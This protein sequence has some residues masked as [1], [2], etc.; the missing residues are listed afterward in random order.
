MESKRVFFAAQVFLGAPIDLHQKHCL[1]Q[2]ILSDAYFKPMTQ[3]YLPTMRVYSSPPGYDCQFVG[4]GIPITKPPHLP[5][6]SILPKGVDPMD[7]FLR[8]VSDETPWEVFGIEFT[9]M[10]LSKW[11]LRLPMAPKKTYF[12]PSNISQHFL[13]YQ[14][15]FF[16][17]QH[18]KFHHNFTNHFFR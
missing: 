9:R 5:R 11:N 1:P 6:V 8:P 10:I 16:T 15:P 13:F 3:I 7:P 12:A 17:P 18:L 14:L 4:S 2:H